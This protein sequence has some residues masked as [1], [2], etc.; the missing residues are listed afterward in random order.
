MEEGVATSTPSVCPFVT[1]T[2]C[3]ETAESLPSKQTKLNR[4]S[5]NVASK[6][7]QS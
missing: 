5:G 3:I 1:L 4:S 6:H 2:H 7:K